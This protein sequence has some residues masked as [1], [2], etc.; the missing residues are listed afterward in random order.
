MRVKLFEGLVKQR[1]SGG[2]ESEMHTSIDWCALS[3]N[4]QQSVLKLI[5]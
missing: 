4:V 3:S 2:G 5:N 1:K